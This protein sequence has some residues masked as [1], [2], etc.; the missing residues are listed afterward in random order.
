MIR[1]TDP[2]RV[3]EIKNSIAEGEMILKAGRSYGRK[4]SIAELDMIKR[5]IKSDKAKIEG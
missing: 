5:S 2:T 3:Q 1:I 4:L